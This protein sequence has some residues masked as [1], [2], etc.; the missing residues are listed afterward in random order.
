MCVVQSS[1]IT[2]G[3]T[4]IK[5]VF[6]QIAP[7]WYNVRHW[8]IFGDELEEL[9]SR[10]RHGRLLNVGCGHGADFLPFRQNFNLYGVDFSI[11]MLKFARRYSKKF[12]FTVNLSLANI[13]YLPFDDKSFD[14]A[15]SVASYHHIKDRKERQTALGELKRVLRPGGEA[16]IT[17]WNHWQPNFWLRPTEITVPWQQKGKILH[18]YYYLFSYM[19][20]ENLVK[21]T[22]FEIVK[23]SPESTYR[24]PLKF[25]SRNICL[26][27]RRSD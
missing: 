25:F 8:S 20:L 2:K 26:L 3:V 19:S 27:V 18:R 10:W 14:L 4:L 21:R 16:F 11:E 22:G 17:V 13:S 9:A 7:G 15:I 24:F 12:N 23:S 1:V 6:N 5:S